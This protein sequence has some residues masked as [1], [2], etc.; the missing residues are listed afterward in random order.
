MKIGKPIKT[1]LGAENAANVFENE[2]S[3]LKC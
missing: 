3:F 2:P 1:I